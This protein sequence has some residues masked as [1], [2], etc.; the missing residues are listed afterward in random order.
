MM[1]TDKIMLSIEQIKQNDHISTNTI[2]NDISDTQKEIN[3]FKAELEAYKKDIQKNR[4][5]IYLTEGQISSREDF[6]SKLKSILE[7]RK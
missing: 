4:T 5:N 1:E 6:V 7:Y 2:E 3:Q